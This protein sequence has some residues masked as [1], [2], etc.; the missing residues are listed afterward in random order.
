[1]IKRFVKSRGMGK[2]LR[3]RLAV[4]ATFVI[5]LYVLAAGVVF[6]GGF[7]EGL[8]DLPAT[9]MRVGAN[10]VPGFLEAPTQEKRLKFVR[11]HVTEHLERPIDRAGRSTEPN[12]DSL[13]DE[14][15]LAERTIPDLSFDEIRTRFDV[16]LEVYGELDDAVLDVEDWGDEVAAIGEELAEIVA[17]GEEDPDLEAE[18]ADSR[19]ELETARSEVERLLPLAERAVMEFQPI[20]D[21]V[22]GFVYRLRTFLGT[23]S[24]GSSISTQAFYAIKIAFQ[25]GLV[26]AII[27]VTIGTLMGAAAAFFG[28]W[29]D[30]AVMWVVSTLSS[31]PYLV[32][33]AVFVYMFRGTRFDNPEQPGLALVPLYA[34]LGLTFWIGTCRVIRGEVMKIKELEFVQ[35]AT[36]IGFGRFYILV[37]HVI[38]NTAH[39]MFINFSLLFIGAI[40]S[41]VILTFLGLG[42]KGQPSWGI[43]IAHGADGVTGFFFWEVGVATVFMF[44]LVLAFNIVSDALQD[45]FDPKHVG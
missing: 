5:G 27:A 14:T 33:L 10:R 12:V 43:M 36:T 15:S 28:G 24:V 25:I 23:N 4:A 8:V 17:D 30:T 26:T 31:I 2:F 13:R 34:A 42:V 3:N 19:E 7:F 6:V 41:E 1:M 11:W 45:A 44:G 39:L 40:K 16:V 9:R 29:V 21:G 20:P 22:W 38:P 37:K 18:L 32:L 35:A